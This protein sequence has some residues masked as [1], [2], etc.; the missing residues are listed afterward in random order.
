M[1]YLKTRIAPKPLQSAL[2]RTPMRRSPPPKKK[3]RFACEPVVDSP[4][5]GEGSSIS[6]P[7]GDQGA[8]EG[9]SAESGA[10]RRRRRA[11]GR[12]LTVAYR[13]EVNERAAED[14]KKAVSSCCPRFLC[15]SLTDQSR[16]ALRAPVETGEE[17]QG[18]STCALHAG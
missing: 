10:E 3:P 15:M 12:T 18:A 1:A 4:A 8:V 14:A 2:D 11:S 13:T 6:T 5:A 16:S 17:A 7:G 9:E